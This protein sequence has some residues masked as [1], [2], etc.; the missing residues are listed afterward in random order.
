[1]RTAL[2]LTAGVVVA[3]V[4]LVPGSGEGGLGMTLGGGAVLALF[5]GIAIW[6]RRTMS[7]H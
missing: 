4:I 3:A 1:M 6:I 2:L 7:H 5:G